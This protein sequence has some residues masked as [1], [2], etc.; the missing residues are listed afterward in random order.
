MKVPGHMLKLTIR[1][2]NKEYVNRKNVHG[3]KT[4][5]AVSGVQKD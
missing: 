3:Q 1:Y 5:L 2:I 4:Y